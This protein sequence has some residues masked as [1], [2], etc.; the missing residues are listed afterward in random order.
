[1]GDLS[2]LVFHVKFILH[3]Q[4]LRVIILSCNCNSKIQLAIFHHYYVRQSQAFLVF[5][6]VYFFFTNNN[7]PV[8][9][10]FVLVKLFII[11]P[12]RHVLV[13]FY[14]SNWYITK[15]TIFMIRNVRYFLNSSYSPYIILAYVEGNF[16]AIK[17][18]IWFIRF[19]RQVVFFI[20]L[21]KD[22]HVSD[23][24]L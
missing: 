5:D 21:Y 24:I 10:R 11:V 19:L 17:S 16:F 13:I 4:P 9:Y 23:I 1:M 6:E 20:Y 22:M 7:F 14:Q 2:V 15:T 12:L 8:I 3:W 18:Y